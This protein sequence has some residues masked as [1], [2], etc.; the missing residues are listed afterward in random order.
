MKTKFFALI[1]LTILLAACSSTKQVG[2]KADSVY[3]GLAIGSSK[4]DIIDLLGKDYKF[5]MNNVTQTAN[6]YVETLIW[7]SSDP[8]VA[9]VL[10]FVNNKLTKKNREPVLKDTSGGTIQINR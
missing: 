4:Q 2:F 7:D 1:T 3:D 9:Y 8:N 10:T 6:N 5:D